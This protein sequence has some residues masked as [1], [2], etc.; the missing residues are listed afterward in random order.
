MR[1]DGTH[2]AA[3]PPGRLPGRGGG[4]GPH[5][6]GRLRASQRR[7]STRCCACTHAMAEAPRA[8]IAR[9]LAVLLTLGA[10]WCCV[11]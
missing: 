3:L 2:G 1:G 10:L 11:L 6:A 4:G 9:R 8:S 7:L 5:L